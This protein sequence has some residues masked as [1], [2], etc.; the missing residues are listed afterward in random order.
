MRALLDSSGIFIP[1]ILGS[2]LDIEHGG[3]NLCMPHELLKSGQRNAGSHHV[4]A[5]GVSQAM[6]VGG[7]DLATQ[8]MIT[9]QRAESGGTQGLSAAAAFQAN[10][11]RRR[12]GQWSFQ[13]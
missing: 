1:H 7:G 4:R 8:A 9:K 11:Q 2:E 6:G 3:V 10:K 13:L 12:V 5:T